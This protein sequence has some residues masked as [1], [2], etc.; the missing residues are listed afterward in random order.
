MT[1]AANLE[2]IYK[3]QVLKTLY[4]KY[5]KFPYVTGNGCFNKNWQSLNR[6]FV[7]VT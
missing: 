4:S 3:F 7:K 1:E 6:Y 5:K 2:K